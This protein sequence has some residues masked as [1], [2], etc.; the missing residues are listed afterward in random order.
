MLK[1]YLYYRPS[2]CILFIWNLLYAIYAV[3]IVNNTISEEP[4]TNNGISDVIW[5]YVIHKDDEIIFI[6]ENI[7]EYGFVDF[8]V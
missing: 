4:L 2:D 3:D 7:K 8:L 5:L 1:G 6:I